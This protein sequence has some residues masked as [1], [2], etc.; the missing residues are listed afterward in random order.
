MAAGLMLLGTSTADAHH[1]PEDTHVGVFRQPSQQETI[2][3]VFATE[4]TNKITKPIVQ[5]NLTK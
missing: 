4:S 1:Q 2:R 5:T 3:T